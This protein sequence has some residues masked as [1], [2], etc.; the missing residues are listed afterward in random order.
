MM[1]LTAE[2]EFNL[3]KMRRGMEEASKEQLI[4]LFFDYMRSTYAKENFY[5]NEIKSLMC[6]QFD[7]ALSE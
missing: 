3:V 2:Q 1:E 7:K 5:Q 4:E 6:Q